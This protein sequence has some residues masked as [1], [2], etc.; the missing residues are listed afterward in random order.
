MKKIV[1]VSIAPLTKSLIDR[2]FVDVVYDSI[3]EM[4]FW[5]LT[6]MFYDQNKLLEYPYI[7]QINTREDLK[8]NID[9]LLINETLVNIQIGFEYKYI[10]I[11]RLFDN[12]KRSFFYMGAFPTF[13]EGKTISLFSL[14]KKLFSLRVFKKII[15]IFVKKS[16][17]VRDFDIIFSTTSE[18][19]KLF[20]NSKILRINYIDYEKI[21]QDKDNIPV[22]YKYVLFLDQNLTGHPD[23]NFV[24]SKPIDKEVYIN[25]LCKLFIYIEEKFSL[26]V[27]IAL[28]PTSSKYNFW[29]NNKQ[30]SNKLYTLI[31]NSEFVIAHYSTSIYAAVSANKPII[32]TTTNDILTK[33]PDTIRITKGLQKNLN[34]LRINLDEMY[35]IDFYPKI[36]SELYEWFLYNYCTDKTIESKFA[37]KYFIDYLKEI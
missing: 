12:F 3:I 23:F 27:I 4:E 2:F 33:L 35:S 15:E 31:N 6:G 36:D 24:E 9:R 7:K 18:I 29:S 32:L 8:K 20:P 14:L 19:N 10:F 11:Y 16:G 26:K 13:K 17:L 37:K 5:D 22:N 34:L 1:Y 21:I 25:Q 28:H 30:Y